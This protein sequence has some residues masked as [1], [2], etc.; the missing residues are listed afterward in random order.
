MRVADLVK[1]CRVCMKVRDLCGRMWASV[2]ET[3]LLSGCFVLDVVISGECLCVK[4][5]L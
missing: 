2:H 5:T 1:V 4:K 3:K